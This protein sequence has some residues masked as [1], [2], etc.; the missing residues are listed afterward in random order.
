MTD[1]NVLKYSILWLHQS[2]SLQVQGLKHLA[3]EMEGDPS[4]L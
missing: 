1:L 3:W 4:L 2:P